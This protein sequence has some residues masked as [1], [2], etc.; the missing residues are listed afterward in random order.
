[1]PQLRVSG[2]RL[3]RH[4]MPHIEKLQT[5]VHAKVAVDQT[6]DVGVQRKSHENAARVQHWVRSEQLDL[7]GLKAGPSR[8]EP[9]VLQFPRQC[10]F[11]LLNG[12]VEFAEEGRVAHQLVHGRHCDSFGPQVT[13]QSPLEPAQVLPIRP[14]R[15]PR[16]VIA[17]VTPIQRV[18]SNGS[19]ES[20]P[21]FFHSH[22]AT[23]PL[24]KSTLARRLVD[25]AGF[26]PATQKLAFRSD[27]VPHLATRT[28]S[29]NFPANV[30]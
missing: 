2:S 5:G 16:P 15:K 19:A 18:T 9:R 1:M 6:Q 26:T 17:D 7:V 27:H 10:L 22:S 11:Q 21:D 12:R 23:L 13:Q 30:M 3:G 25:R 24:C 4:S 14:E 28:H 8:V 20:R 29:G